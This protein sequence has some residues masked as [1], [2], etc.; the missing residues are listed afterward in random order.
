MSKWKWIAIGLLLPICG[1][2]PSVFQ[3]APP[4]TELHVAAAA[5]LA[6]IFDELAAGV[7]KKTGARLIPSFGSTAQLTKQ[8]EAGAP[9]D[10][11]LAADSEHPISLASSGL[12]STPHEYARGRLVIWAPRRNDIQTLA[13]LLK[14]DVK[15]IAVA[16]PDIAPYGH[17][18]VEA[19]TNAQ[20]WDRVKGKVV[21]GQ[22]ISASLNFVDTGNADVGLTAFSLVA[23]HHPKAPLV[24]ADLHHPIV[25]SLCILN[26]TNQ[27]AEAKAC[28]DFLLGP[29]GRKIFEKN[30]YS[31]P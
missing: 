18:A 27:M 3:V 21:Y 29:E 31:V 14:P 15:V 19:L 23:A 20:L 26:R 30:G 10:L 4:P 1:C 9:F 25:Q 12:A 2:G 17:A 11:F 13:D 28:V 16:N 7:R 5:N 24:P 8:I 22:N 6:T